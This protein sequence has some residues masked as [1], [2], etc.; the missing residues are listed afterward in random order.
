MLDLENGIESLTNLSHARDFPPQHSS[1]V[2][3]PLP[4]GVAYRHSLAR[5]H[6][7]PCK[8]NFPV[9]PPPGRAKLLLSRKTSRLLS[10]LPSPPSASPVLPAH[11]QTLPAAHR[12]L[13][14]SGETVATEPLNWLKEQPCD[15]WAIGDLGSPSRGIQPIPARLRGWRGGFTQ[16]HRALGRSLPACRD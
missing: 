1:S 10:G 3:A 16:S 2:M 7:P 8:P 13:E 6:A 12:H 5:C 11:D 9:F 15:S 4:P 14:P